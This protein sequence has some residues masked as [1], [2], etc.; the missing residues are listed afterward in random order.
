MSQW[1]T[2]L[3]ST[4][5]APAEAIRANT[6]TSAHT[7]VDRTV[8]SRA[9]TVDMPTNLSGMTS[10]THKP[11][12]APTPLKIE[13]LRDYLKDYPSPDKEYLLQGLEFGFKIPFE[14]S[15]PPLSV[16]NHKS[17]LSSLRLS[18]I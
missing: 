8:P 5:P 13:V 3:H 17:V 1:D 4:A 6:S 7:V 2:A 15:L 11:T 16:R 9:P 10:E 12:R 18:Q 14:G